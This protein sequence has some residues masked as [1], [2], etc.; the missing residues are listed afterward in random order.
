MKNREPLNDWEAEL[1]RELDTLPDLAAPTTL[2]PRVMSEV[3]RRAQAPW[4]RCAWREWP[5]ALQAACLVL[6]IGAVGTLVWFS[7][8][9]WEATGGQQMSLWRGE[10]QTSWSATA[11]GMESAFGAGAAFW[12]Q[13]GQPLLFGIAAVLMATYLTCIAAGTALYRMAWRRA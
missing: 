8:S 13:Y 2:L 11:S 10:V 9:I 5:V 7:G 3:H 6:M 1:H 12:K 4:Y